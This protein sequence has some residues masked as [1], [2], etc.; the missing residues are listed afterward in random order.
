MGY[1][2]CNEKLDKVLSD[3][4]NADAGSLVR[5]PWLTGKGLT[6]AGRVGVIA[7]VANGLIGVAVNESGR[8]K[9]FYGRDRT[10]SWFFEVWSIWKAAAVALVMLIV[11]GLFLSLGPGMVS[12]VG[13]LAVGAASVAAFGGRAVNLARHWAV[14]SAIADVKYSAGVMPSVLGFAA[15]IGFIAAGAMVIGGAEI[16]ERANLNEWRDL[17]LGLA[18][19]LIALKGLFGYAVII[20]ASKFFWGYG[21]EIPALRAAVDVASKSKF[22]TSTVY[23]ANVHGDLGAE[24]SAARR[25]GNGLVFLL[26][27]V[28]LVALAGWPLLPLIVK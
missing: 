28:V 27:P 23:A 22:Y 26:L 13:L 24:Y 10:G 12:G 4:A 3:C 2:A 18:V 21:M 15:G 9:F 17:G 1:A 7:S 6:G 19:G 25:K 8:Y 11:A 5:A 14:A 20:V 16:G